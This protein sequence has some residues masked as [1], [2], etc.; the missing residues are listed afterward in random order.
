VGG[1]QRGGVADG[2][3]D[4]VEA[5][6]ALSRGIDGGGAEFDAVDAAAGGGDVEGEAPYPAIEVPYG[7]GRGGVDPVAGL[8]VETGGDGGVGLEE[9][10]GAEVQDDFAEAHGE[11]LADERDLLLALKH[12]LVL[13]L[14]VGSDD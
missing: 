3:G 7:G 14:E 11:G 13:G 2:E 12:G 9:A 1:G 6:C 4:A 8:C 10:A 5:G